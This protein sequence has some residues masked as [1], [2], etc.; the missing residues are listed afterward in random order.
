VVLVSY[1]PGVG[2]FVGGTKDRA[3]VNSI[4]VSQ[5]NKRYVTAGGGK[6]VLVCAVV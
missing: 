2:H 1:P 6:L 3:Q 4:A 5:I